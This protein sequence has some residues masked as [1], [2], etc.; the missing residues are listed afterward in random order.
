M[1]PDVSCELVVDHHEEEREREGGGG[2]YQNGHHRDNWLVAAKRSQRHCLWILRCRAFLS[3]NRRSPK[4]SDCFLPLPLALSLS[5]SLLLSRSHTLSL[6]VS[7]A[8]S[9]TPSLPPFL[10]HRPPLGGGPGRTIEVEPGLAL[11]VVITTH[12]GERFWD[13]LRPLR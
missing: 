3:L 4:V 7:L 10:S 9:F 5:Y 8:L 12:T 13:T 6:A 2:R 1:F 11:R